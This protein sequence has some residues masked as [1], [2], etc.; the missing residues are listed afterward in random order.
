MERSLAVAVMGG[1]AG[2]FLSSTFLIPSILTFLEKTGHDP[3]ME[4]MS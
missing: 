4:G 3:E 1:L 2:S